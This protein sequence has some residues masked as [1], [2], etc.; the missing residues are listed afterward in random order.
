LSSWWNCHHVMARKPLT[1]VQLAVGAAVSAVSLAVAYDLWRR[2]MR[3]STR[4]TTAT[5]GR[6]SYQRRVGLE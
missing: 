5:A 3:E 2:R 6:D 4:E 1:H